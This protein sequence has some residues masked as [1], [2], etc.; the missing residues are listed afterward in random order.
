MLW[1]LM[2]SMPA[3]VCPPGG[4][5]G[6]I[7]MPLLLQQLHQRPEG[8]NVEATKETHSRA[9]SD[10]EAR[11]KLL[12]CSCGPMSNARVMHGTSKEP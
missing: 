4:E 10:A 5:G 11:L 1:Q 8:R 3:P 7:C 9:A 6:I 12:H 2:N